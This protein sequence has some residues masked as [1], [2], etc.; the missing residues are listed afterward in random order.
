MV[1]LTRLAAAEGDATVVRLPSLEGVLGEVEEGVE[2][3]MREAEAGDEAP[4]QHRK[5]L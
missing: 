1:S 3:R 2:V 5:G 4:L